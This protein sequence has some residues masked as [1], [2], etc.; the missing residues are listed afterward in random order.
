MPSLNVFHNHYH[1]NFK[2]PRTVD[3]IHP[4]DLGFRA[5]ANAIAP[6]LKKAL[7]QGKLK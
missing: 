6:Q 7:T 1:H 3:G 5:M 4:N 2:K